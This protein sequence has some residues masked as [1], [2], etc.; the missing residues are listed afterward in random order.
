[1]YTAPT[2]L[3]SFLSY[4]RSIAPR[5]PEGVVNTPPSPAMSSVLVTSG[6]IRPARPVR[7]IVSPLSDGL[8]RTLSAVSPCAMYQRISPL[9]RSI[10]LMRAYGGFKSGRPRTV[11]P[12]PPSPPPAAAAAAALGAAAAGCPAVAPPARGAAAG[13]SSPVRPPPAADPDPP[14]RRAPV[15]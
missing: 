10:A 12:P 2:S 11:R 4:A 6:L 7:G 5:A 15:I 14:V 9:F 8:L 3:P 13:A 1:M